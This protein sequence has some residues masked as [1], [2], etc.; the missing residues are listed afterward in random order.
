MPVLTRKKI[1][2]RNNLFVPKYTGSECSDCAMNIKYNTCFFVE[3]R[4]MCDHTYKVYPLKDL[5]IKL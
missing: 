3:K 4:I 2:Y 1:K 5:L